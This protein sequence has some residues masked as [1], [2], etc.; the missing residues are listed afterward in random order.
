VARLRIREV[1]EQKGMSMGLLSRKANV[2]LAVIRKIWRNDQH[3]VSFNTL[4]KIAQ[5]LEV[6]VSE[7]IEDGDAPPEARQ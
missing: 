7:L 6:R 4:Q 2:T 1:A 3:D 5:A